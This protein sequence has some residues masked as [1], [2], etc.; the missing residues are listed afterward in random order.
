M[1]RS[2]SPS[3]VYQPTTQALSTTQYQ[4]VPTAGD[5]IESGQGRSATAQQSSAL[6]GLTKAA[7]WVANNPG[8][9][10]V[11]VLWA[12]GAAAAAKLASNY[13]NADQFGDIQDRNISQIVQ[14]EISDKA[15][16]VGKLINDTLV[17]GTYN[18]GSFQPGPSSLPDRMRGQSWESVVRYVEEGQFKDIPPS[19]VTFLP[20]NFDLREYLRGAAANSQEPQ[21]HALAENDAIEGS[22]SSAEFLEARQRLSASSLDDDFRQAA[23]LAGESFSRAHPNITLPSGLSPNETI[24]H[25]EQQGINRYEIL[26]HLSENATTV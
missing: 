15:E 7:K 13:Q 12:F 26:K 14:R 2:V 1:I 23:R 10:T 24:A 19:S 16:I 5:D 6:N 11:G 3:S 8:K 20:D 25:L 21:E 4:R 17:E 18:N 22:G 9:A